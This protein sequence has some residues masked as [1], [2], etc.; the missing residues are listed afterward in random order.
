MRKRRIPR[1]ETGRGTKRGKRE[2][3]REEGK[4]RARPKKKGPAMSASS[5]RVGSIE[6]TGDN[7]A[8]VL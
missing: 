8:T 6:P 3:K 4:P 1:E 2:E 5:M 7:T